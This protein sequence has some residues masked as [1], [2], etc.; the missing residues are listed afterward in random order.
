[1]IILYKLYYVISYVFCIKLY[2]ITNN[3]NDG[4]GGAARSTTNKTAS[5]MPPGRSWSQG[6]C[7][8]LSK[9]CVLY[10]SIGVGHTRVSVGYTWVSA[11]H[12]SISVGHTRVSVGNRP[13]HGRSQQD[14]KLDASWKQ[15]AEE[16]CLPIP[17]EMISIRLNERLTAN[18]AFRRGSISTMPVLS[19]N[20]SHTQ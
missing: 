3:H 12:A 8:S 1:M 14:C 19:L 4:A 16:T 9:W 7:P 11:V 10:F 17:L 20:L 2:K 15:L 13:K 6:A 5:S 18:D